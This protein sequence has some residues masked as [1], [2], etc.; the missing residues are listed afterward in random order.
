MSNILGDSH[1]LLSKS[2]S[3]SEFSS[4]WY[5]LD[6]LTF[7]LTFWSFE[8]LLAVFSLVKFE[9]LDEDEDEEDDDELIGDTDERLKLLREM[10]ALELLF[11]ALSDNEFWMLAGDEGLDE[12][13]DGMVWL[14][15][16]GEEIWLHWLSDV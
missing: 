8:L 4:A 14:K 7:K 2:C 9:R 13:F 11:D 15:L 3:C 10:I 1:E 12:P 5:E 16:T 6:S